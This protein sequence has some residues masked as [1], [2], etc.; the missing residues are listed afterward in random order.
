MGEWQQVAD[1]VYRVQLQPAAVN[2]G[3]VV[4]E[5]GVLLVDTGSSPAQ[6]RELAASAAALAGRPL[7]HVVVTHWHFDHFFGLAGVLQAFPQAVSVGHETMMAHL[8]DADPDIDPT[9]IRDQLGFDKHELIAPSQEISLI[10]AIDLGGRRVEIVHLGQ[11]H[12]DGDLFV[13]CPEAGVIFTGD[14]IETSG[15][16]AIGPDS[17]V[18]AWPKAIDGVVSH[19]KDNA[20][21]VFV[22]GH[23]DPVDI[24]FVLQQRANISMLWGTAEDLVKKGISQDEALADLNGPRQHEWPFEPQTIANVLPYLYDELARAGVTKSKFLPVV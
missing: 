6:G 21:L 1:G 22:P 13:L 5:T 16:P 23:G 8:D 18:Q 4:G 15:D 12:T 17:T 14:L 19:A 2:A 24:D 9:V 7:T 11:G 10:K 20:G 3:L